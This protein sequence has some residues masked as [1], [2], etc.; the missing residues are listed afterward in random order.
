MWTTSK[1]AKKLKIKYPIIQAPM[2]GGATTAELVAAVSNAG[3]LGSLGAAYMTGDILRSAIIKIRELT[4]KPFAVNLFIPNEHHASLK[5]IQQACKFLEQACSE[6]NTKI[7]PV[8]APYSPSYTEQMSVIV[9]EKVPVFSF[10]F[11]IP[12]N[13]WIAKLKENNCLLIGTATNVLEAIELEKSGVDVVVAQGSEAGGHR[14]TFIGKAEDSLIGLLSLLPQLVDHIKI[15]VIASG[16]IMNAKGIVA[17]LTLGADAVQMGT[18]F[19]TCKESGIHPL[20]KKALLNTTKDNTV[21]TSAFSGRLARGLRNKFIERLSTHKEYILPFPIQNAMSRLMRNEA[22]KQNCT[23]FMSMWA[24]QT[25]SLCKEM[26]TAELMKELV[27]EI[28]SFYEQQPH[29]LS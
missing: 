14:G 13:N 11:G 20:Y 26:S 29:S 4:D 16:G 18:A 22:A 6:L 9:E 27:D 23:D 17:S 24:G 12:D 10:I 7:P 2:A 5:Q 8:Q 28:N 15:P 1:L 19:L 25:A 21:L 3:G